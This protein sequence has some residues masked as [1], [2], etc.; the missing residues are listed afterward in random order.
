MPKGDRYPSM[1]HIPFPPDLTKKER[2]LYLQGVQDGVQ[3]V[4]DRQMSCVTELA[5]IAQ[6]LAERAANE[7]R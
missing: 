1:P 3:I 2:A 5:L 7:P 4:R 6:K